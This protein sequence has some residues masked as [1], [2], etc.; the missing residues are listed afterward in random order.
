M[1]ITVIPVFHYERPI[2]G[3][4]QLP[5]SVIL[6]YVAVFWLKHLTNVQICVMSFCPD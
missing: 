4:E 3:Q 2:R 6:A 5:A 1:Q